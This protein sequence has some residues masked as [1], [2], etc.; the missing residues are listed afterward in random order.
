MIKVLLAD[1]QL[2]V[3]TGIAMLLASS[4]DVVVVGEAEDGGRAVE[5]AAELQPDVL[6]MDVRMPGVDGVEATRRVT[7]DGF[8]PDPDRPVKVLIL[9]T[10]NV[11]ATVYAALRAGAS[12][13]LLKDAAPDELV[14]AVRA[15]ADGDGWLDPSVTRG[16]L[17]EFAERPE[18]HLPTPAEMAVLTPREREV[19]VLMAHGLSNAEISRRLFIGEGTTKTHVGR[20]LTKLSLRDRAQ[21]VATAYQSGLVRP[22]AVLPELRSSE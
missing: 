5:L 11:D 10:Y 6:L 18:T 16:L 9:T 1:D 15:L 12:G 13:F 19:L 7:A 4:P 3:R 20:I 17:R 21:A 8:A 2:L 14:S 22:G